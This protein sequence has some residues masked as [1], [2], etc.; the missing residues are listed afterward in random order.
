MSGHHHQ[1]FHFCVVLHGVD[2]LVLRIEVLLGPFYIP[3]K[4]MGG[5]PKDVILYSNHVP[6]IDIYD[7]LGSALLSACLQ[8]SQTA[9][10]LYT[11]E[12]GRPTSTVVCVTIESVAVDRTQFPFTESTIPVRRMLC[13][14][15]VRGHP[16]DR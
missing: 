14:S 15:G 6:Y 1:R 3:L 2:L 4:F 5:Y 8:L 9:G 10:Y 13:S 7:F 12:L 16:G 11:V